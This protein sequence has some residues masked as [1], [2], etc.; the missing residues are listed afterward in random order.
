MRSIWKKKKKWSILRLVSKVLNN[1][2]VIDIE[3]Q[4]VIDEIN[5]SPI[6]ITPSKRVS[7]RNSRESVLLSPRDVRL[8]NLGSGLELSLAKNFKN[9]CRSKSLLMHFEFQIHMKTPSW[10]FVWNHQYEVKDVQS[11]VIQIQAPFYAKGRFINHL[12]YPLSN[13][14]IVDILEPFSQSQS[15][16]RKFK[17]EDYSVRLKLVN[18]WLY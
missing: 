2:K 5:N 6:I 16:Q 10:A 8:K 14:W 12:C 4:I 11:I 1:N 9:S 7:W 13:R 17:G 15:T 18:K 3:L